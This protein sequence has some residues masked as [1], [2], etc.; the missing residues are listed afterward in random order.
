MHH[1]LVTGARFALVLSLG[2]LAVACA[3]TV[4]T[5]PPRA[6]DAGVG[7]E[8]PSGSTGTTERAPRLDEARQF[9]QP[10]L[11]PDVLERDALIAS[12]LQR[13]PSIDAVR[14]AWKAAAARS[15]QVGSLEDPMFSY[16]FAP[17]SIDSNKVD[18]GER[19]EISQRLPWPGKL[20]LKSA[21]AIDD[22][23]ARFQDVEEAKIEIAMKAAALFDDYYLVHRALELNVEHIRLLEELKRSA[24]A[25]Y[26]AGVLS[27]QE[28]IQAEVELAHLAHED[29]VLNAERRILTARL[30]ALL[31]RPPGERLP[32][33]AALSSEQAHAVVGLAGD[34]VVRLEDLAVTRRPEIAAAEAAIRARTAEVSLVGLEGFPDFGVMGEYNSMWADEDHQWMAGF[35]MTLPIWRQRIRAARSEADARLTAAERER[36]ALEDGVRSEARQA[37]ER[38]VEAHHILELFNSR[39]LPAAGDQLRV[40]RAGLES[41]RTNFMS[42]I[43]A[44]R[45]LRD[46]QLRYEAALSS[47]D[48]RI[49][50]LSRQLGCL[51][52]DL[53][54]VLSSLELVDRGLA[55][56]DGGSR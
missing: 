40:S 48:T 11:F 23:D 56:A 22:A 2:T 4:P 21:A 20:R 42:L 53:E 37:Y 16:S 26:A 5:R 8:A 39:L 1:K 38:V 50:E 35:S 10:E 44:E 9:E 27:Q 30:N 7:V 29:V 3:P 13:N 28:P 36:Q 46:V 19:A 17:L 51:P 43:D 14:Q 47:L 24:V 41:G 54:R 45:N 32:P 31:H 49:A 52:A 33:P 55:A 25:Q 12:V 15:P 18:F 6:R 34:D